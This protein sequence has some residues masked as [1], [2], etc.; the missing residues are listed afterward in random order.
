MIKG[1]IQ[2]DLD[3]FGKVNDNII[4]RAITLITEIVSSNTRKRIQR[5]E[6]KGRKYQRRTSRA[7]NRYRSYI[8]NPDPRTEGVIYSSLG[9]QSAKGEPPKSDTG[10]LVGLIKTN[11]KSLNNRIGYVLSGAEYSSHLE[12]KLDRPI[13]KG[14]PDKKTRQQIERAI[15]Q[16]KEGV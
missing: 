6:R 2:I 12:D 16:I 13:F 3:K 9:Q 15:S 10:T 4:K 14:Q 1:E 11:L 7:G 5:G 8:I